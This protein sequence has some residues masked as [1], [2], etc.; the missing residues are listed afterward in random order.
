MPRGNLTDC[1]TPQSAD[2]GSDLMDDTVTP[3]RA[4]ATVLRTEV[5]PN[6][7]ETC[8]IAWE[9][10]IETIVANY[11]NVVLHFEAAVSVCG[12]LALPKPWKPVALV[13]EGPSGPGKSTIP[14]VLLGSTMEE[15]KRNLYRSDKFSPA[16]FVSQ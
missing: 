12:I 1:Y 15:I 8:S 10:F 9:G 16:A 7:C 6:G 4:S 14:N 5:D 2:H 13:Y 11:P 3:F